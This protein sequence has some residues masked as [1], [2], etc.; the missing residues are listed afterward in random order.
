MKERAFSFSRI[1][2]YNSCS[3]YFRLYYVD[4]PVARPVTD[5]V[6]TVMGTLVHETLEEFY[7]PNVDRA[8]DPVQILD[9]IWDNRLQQLGLSHVKPQLMSIAADVVRLNQRASADYVGPDA[10]R[11]EKGKPYKSPQRSNAWA[12]A[13]RELK[14]DQRRAAIDT[15]AAA[16]GKPWSA[17]SLSEV[18]AETFA[19]LEPYNDP[20]V[21][22][23]L[24]VRAQEVPLSSPAQKGEAYM[25]DPKINIVRLPNGDLYTGYIDSICTDA[26]GRTYIIDHKTSKEAPT[27]AKVAHWEQL[28]LYAW[29]HY[30]VWGFYPHYIGINSV[31]HG[32]LIIAPFNPALVEG[33]LR[34]FMSGI[35]GA[36]KRAFVQQSPIA[37]G[38]QC[39]KEFTKTPCPY[40]GYC[41]PE[42]ARAVGVKQ[43]FQP[44]TVA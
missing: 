3:E 16:K 21:S 30:Q 20:F 40:L 10:I 19:V 43:T 28:I 39:Y 27:Q 4:K 7:G 17:V 37:H 23:G 31:R 36:D 41:H 5:T 32:Q 38:A 22:V 1:E 14:L 24:T 6:A 35:D 13:V 8:I 33:T 26:L 29:A 42:F 34:R 9:L 2:K 12:Q 44:L 25:N 11:D 15:L 18:Y